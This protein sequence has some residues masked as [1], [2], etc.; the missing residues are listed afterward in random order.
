[1]QTKTIST[2]AGQAFDPKIEKARAELERLEGAAADAEAEA[3]RWKTVFEREPTEQAFASRGVAEQRARNARA[4]AD[5]YVRDV[6]AP[7]EAAQRSAERKALADAIGEEE[8]SIRDE[9]QDALAAFI[10]GARRL[11]GAIKLLGTMHDKRLAATQK[12]ALLG[13]LSLGQIV[14]S[15]NADLDEFRGESFELPGKHAQIVFVENG[16]DA[17]VAFTLNRPANVPSTVR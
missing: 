13:S 8:N 12:G 9:F 15:M 5:A 2:D 1:M 7:L 14:A 3:A 16:R 10:D 4:A 6:L 17:H 11:D